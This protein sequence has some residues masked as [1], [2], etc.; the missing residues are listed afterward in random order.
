VI[1]VE[2]LAKLYGDFAAV[3]GVSFSVG[4]GELLGLV[5]HNGAG[6]TTTLRCLA[7]VFPA[8]KG[9]IRIGGYD[10][11]A[12]PIK[13][14]RE[15]AYFPDEP[16]LF[17][18]LTVRQHLEF[19][20]RLYQTPDAAARTPALLAELELTEKADVL[21]GE[22][23]RGMKQKVALA[24]GLIH[25]P[26]VLIFDE[27]L[28]GLDPLAIRRT[29]ETIRR[30]GAEGAS[31]IISSHLLHLLEELCTHVLIMQ[32]GKAVAYGRMDEVRRSFSQGGDETLEDVF[33]RIAM[34]S[35]APPPPPMPP[36]GAATVSGDEATSPPLPPPSAPDPGK[37]DAP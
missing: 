4:P 21:P 12:D 24:C 34:A 7:G 36:R 31:L 5:G 35:S 15:L 9:I 26:R 37:T 6:K 25:K 1:E 10:I 18:N 28:T 32:K 13:A 19:V 11:K 22:L 29:K 14:K 8:T 30:L 3:D 20:A 23:S 16:R 2:G 33:V 17:D 27:P